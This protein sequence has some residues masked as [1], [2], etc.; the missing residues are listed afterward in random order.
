METEEIC[1]NVSDT[2]QREDDE[3]RSKHLA[4]FKITDIAKVLFGGFKNTTY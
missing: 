1:V 3:C 2:A 4:N